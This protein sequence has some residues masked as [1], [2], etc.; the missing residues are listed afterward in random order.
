MSKYSPDGKLFCY[1]IISVKDANFYFVNDGPVKIYDKEMALTAESLI[2]NQTYG[3]R[4]I[5]C[6]W[7]GVKEYSQNYEHDTG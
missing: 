5:K 6:Y 4:W 3:D 1:K 7:N 2:K